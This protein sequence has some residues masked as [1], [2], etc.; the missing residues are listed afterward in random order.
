M[1]LEIILSNIHCQSCIRNLDE[2]IQEL[3][4]G[5]KV[6]GSIPEQK[7]WIETQTTLTQD[8]IVALKSEITKAGY[9]VK[10]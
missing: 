8:E 7:I 6:R 1:T 3:T 10:G 4:P 2:I 5:A 9:P